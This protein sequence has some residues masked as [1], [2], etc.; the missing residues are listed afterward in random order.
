MATKSPA[1]WQSLA[2]LHQLASTPSHAAGRAQGC[3]SVGPKGLRGHG[4]AGLSSGS[5]K[6]AREGSCKAS[7][8]CLPFPPHRINPCGPQVWPPFR[9]HSSCGRCCLAAACRPCTPCPPS[10]ALPHPLPSPSPPLALPTP[11]HP[12]SHRLWLTTCST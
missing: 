10:L 8:L 12:T 5:Q 1:A 7:P 6:G 3:G 9:P 11:T 2:G 4:A